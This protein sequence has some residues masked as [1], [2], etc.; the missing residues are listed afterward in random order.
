MIKLKAIFKIIQKKIKKYPEL[1]RK[2][3]YKQTQACLFWFNQI[4]LILEQL[5]LELRPDL[6]K[7]L[8]YNKK[9][10]IGP[11]Q[12]AIDSFIKLFYLLI[13]FSHY[14]QQLPEI[15]SYF[16]ITDKLVPYM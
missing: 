12:Y 1:I 9:K 8:D 2:D 3:N 15:L 14:N 11:I 13:V 7:M 4:I 6:N 5:T 10:I 16:S